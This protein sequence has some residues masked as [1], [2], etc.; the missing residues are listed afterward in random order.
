MYEKCKS[1][2]V[3]M[4]RNYSVLSSSIPL[5]EVWNF[6]SLFALILYK[7]INKLLTDCFLSYIQIRR[8]NIQ[9]DKKK[10]K[11]NRKIQFQ[12]SGYPKRSTRSASQFIQSSN[13]APVRWSR[14]TTTIATTERHRSSLKIIVFTLVSNLKIISLL[15]FWVVFTKNLVKKTMGVG[16]IIIRYNDH[17]VALYTNWVKH[18]WAIYRYCMCIHTAH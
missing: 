8:T 4:W 18:K 1:F 5:S 16:Q 14:D 9:I 10:K 12:T 7:I 2:F 15:G 11:F 3:L 13:Q 6:S 17:I